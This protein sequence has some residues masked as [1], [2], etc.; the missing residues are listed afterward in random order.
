MS[1]STLNE[2]ID[3]ARK[4]NPEF[5]QRLKESETLAFWEEA[6][7]PHIAKHTQ[8]LSVKEG[9]L[10]IA[11][12]HPV[13]K[14]ELFLRKNQILEK[15]NSTKNETIIKDLFFIDLNARNNKSKSM[16]Q[17]SEGSPLKK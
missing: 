12:D 3:Y 11:V 5:S 6:V 2:I 9:T 14:S 13:W 15:L 4:L 10:M 7:G 8:L 16:F 17:K 1:F